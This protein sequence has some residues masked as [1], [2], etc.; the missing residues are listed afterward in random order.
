[1]SVVEY[2][3]VGIKKDDETQLILGHAGFIKTAEDLYEAMAGAAPG[4]KFGVAFA[5][6][7][8]KRL[9]RTEGNDGALE[10]QA[11]ENLLSIAAGH[12]FLVLFRGAFPINVVKHVSGVSEVARIYCATANSV[13]VIVAS[14]GGSSSVLGVIDG[15]DSIGIENSADKVE[16]REFVRKIGYKK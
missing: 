6:A 11:A 2:K 15:Q 8:G 10:K 16:R 12:T 14:E 3:I 13:K 1:M 4:I 5:E 9:V 7:S